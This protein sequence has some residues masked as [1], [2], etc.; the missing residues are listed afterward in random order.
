MSELMEYA[1][2]RLQEA[3]NGGEDTAT[4]RYWVGY[5]D[6]LRAAERKSAASANAK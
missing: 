4:I 6:G 3:C 5:I 1:Q 2:K